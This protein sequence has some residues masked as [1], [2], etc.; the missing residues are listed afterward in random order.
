MDSLN[1]NRLL[2]TI[3]R[4]MR[5]H[6]QVIINPEIPELTIENLEPMLKMVARSRAAYLKALFE[7]SSEVDDGLPNG[8]QIDA[9]H[10]LRYSYNELLEGAQALEAAIERGY[11]DVMT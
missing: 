8:D 7:L 3:E 1:K 10:A 5:A 9:L 4:E 11:L 6:N 2:L